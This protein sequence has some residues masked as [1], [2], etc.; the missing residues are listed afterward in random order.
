MVLGDHTINPY[1]ATRAALIATLDIPS[2]SSGPVSV[3]L[4]G[5]GTGVGRVPFKLCAHQMRRAIEQVVLQ[6]TEF[7]DSWMEA[8]DLV[9]DLL[10]I[11]RTP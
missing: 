3:C 8:T 5:M 10:G 7:P 6:T 11:K 4:P 9:D 1:M 2:G